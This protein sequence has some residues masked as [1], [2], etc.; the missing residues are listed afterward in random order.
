VEDLAAE[1]ES[2]RARVQQLEMEGERAHE[3]G[4]GI[5]D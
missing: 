3:E 5:R 2:L 4:L 1:L